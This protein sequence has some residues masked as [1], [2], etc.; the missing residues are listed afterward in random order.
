MTVSLNSIGFD[1]MPNT[2]V[3]RF[4][5]QGLHPPAI[6][7]VFFPIEATTIVIRFD[8][9]ATNRAGMNGVDRGQV[10]DDATADILKGEASEEALCDWFD[11]TSMFVQLARRC[12]GGIT[13][14]L[15]TASSGPNRGPIRARWARQYVLLQQVDDD[16]RRLPVRSDQHAGA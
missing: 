12:Y 15:R 11:D 14:R 16:R 13:I 10:L 8:A 6:V 4:F 3:P 1:A 9:Q 5:Y 2:T 7:E